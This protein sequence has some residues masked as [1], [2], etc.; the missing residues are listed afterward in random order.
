MNLMMVR[1]SGA[2]TTSIAKVHRC[3]LYA[4]YCILKKVNGYIEVLAREEKQ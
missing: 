3:T 2:L 4:A 1:I